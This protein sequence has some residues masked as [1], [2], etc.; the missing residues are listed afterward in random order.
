[1]RNFNFLIFLMLWLIYRNNKLKL[2][3]SFAKYK[4]NYIIK[5]KEREQDNYLEKKLVKSRGIIS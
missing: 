2:S 5:L 3:Q 1:M 4:K